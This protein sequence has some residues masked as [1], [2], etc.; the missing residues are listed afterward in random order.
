[1]EERIKAGTW[2]IDENMF[3]SHMRARLF[4]PFALSTLSTLDFRFCTSKHS[5]YEGTMAHL[6]HALHH[7]LLQLGHSWEKQG[8]LPSF[9][10]CNLGKIHP[11][12]SDVVSHQCNRN[13]PLFLDTVVYQ[14]LRDGLTLTLQ[15]HVNEVGSTICASMCT[16]HVSGLCYSSSFYKMST[17]STFVKIT[18]V[19][20]HANYSQK[21]VK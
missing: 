2:Q 15:G 19:C 7:V 14:R 13:N 12:L 4:S 20:I 17:T 1:M 3:K 8:L 18:L 5:S 6:V 21:L 9:A 16:L 11:P 10:T